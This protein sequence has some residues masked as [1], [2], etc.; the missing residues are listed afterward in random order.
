M[1]LP[2]LSEG[3]QRMVESLEKLLWEERLAA[4]KEQAH[5]NAR[6]MNALL[7]GPPEHA[8]RALEVGADPNARF[9]GGTALTQAIHHE[10]LAMVRVLL[11]AGANPDLLAKVYQPG[12]A[13][14]FDVVRKA[15]LA[16]AC[17]R[18]YKAVMEML[19]D[20]GAK[21]DALGHYKNA[22]LLDAAA[23]GCI[24][25][26]KK[27]IAAGVPVDFKGK[28]GRDGIYS[29]VAL[30]TAWQTP[31]MLAAFYA[32]PGMVEF[33][34]SAG[35][36]ANVKDGKGHTALDYTQIL[37]A[38]GWRRVAGILEKASA[39]AGKNFEEPKSNVP[40]FSEQAARPEFQKALAKLRKLT[41][42]KA[43][44][45]QQIEG[46]VRGGYVFAKPEKPAWALVKKYHRT[47]LREGAYLFFTRDLAAR[48]GPAVAVLP[49]TDL[50]QVLAAVGTEG[51]DDNMYNRNLIRWLLKLKKQQ[52]IEILGVGH[53]FVEGFFTAP[54]RNPEALARSMAR[55]CAELGDEPAAIRAEAARLKKTKRFFLWWD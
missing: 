12:R 51:P 20:A 11:N 40:D 37:K 46:E 42:S 1:A 5:L 28:H 31:L 6:L 14:R 8:E 17:E 10:R 2:T 53:D 30:P 47:F 27:L 43:L 50:A 7:W 25:L 15:P 9:P 39:V 3:N 22:A 33:L 41:G 36:D 26:A 52:S 4:T 34:L 19:L 35:A 45:M 18:G 49:T 32:A 16:M 24:P 29:S 23:A 54:V 44:A 21:V 13:V 48:N 55:I 38:R